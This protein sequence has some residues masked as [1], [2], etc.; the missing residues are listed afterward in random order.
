MHA[1]LRAAL[2][3]AVAWDM[4]DRNPALGV[5]LPRKKARKPTIVLPLRAIRDLIQV[6]PNQS[7]L[8]GVNTN[9]AFHFIASH[10]INSES[11]N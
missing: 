9:F 8:S 4:L 11:L 7:H 10:E 6:L 2:N 5:K 3:Q 1:A